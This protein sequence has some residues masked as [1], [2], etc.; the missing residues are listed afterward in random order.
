MTEDVPILFF[1]FLVVW[2]IGRLVVWEI[3]R[4]GVLFARTTGLKDFFHFSSLIPH[5]SLPPFRPSPL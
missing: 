4:L 3:G 5:S 1:I 2:E